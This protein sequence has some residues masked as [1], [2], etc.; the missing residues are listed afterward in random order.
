MKNIFLIVLLGIASASNGQALRDINFNYQYERGDFSFLI[1]AVRQE[2]GWT[3]FYKLEIL[4]TGSYDIDQFTIAWEKRENV[5]VKEGAAVFSDTTQLLESGKY[6]VVGKLQIEA[7]QAPQYIVAKITNRALLKSGIYFKMLEPDYPVNAY[8][9]TESGS[10]IFQPFISAGMPVR[11][12]GFEA[13]SLLTVSYYGDSFPPALP[14]LSEGQP[15]VSRNMQP[16]SSFTI[17]ASRMLTFKKKGLYLIQNDPHAATALAFRVEEAYPKFTRLQ[18]LGGPFVYICTRQEFE[19]IKQAGTD[20]KAFDKVVLELANDTDRART[21]MRN[22]FKRVELSNQYFTSYKEGWKTDRGMIHL[23]YGLPKRVTKLS[24]REVWVYE[25]TN[26]VFMKSGSLF[27]PDAF[28][29]KRDRKYANQ[30]YEKVD[31]IRNS[32]FQ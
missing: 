13:G 14:P 18:D 5:N 22:Y 21:L 15:P 24:D 3:I 27:D 19:K 20:K 23:I 16:D 12:E 8:M 31:L 29:L 32:R 1:K 28:V 6:S 7:S 2:A 10:V 9:K 30:W 26:L 11:I 17:K 25:N 4:D